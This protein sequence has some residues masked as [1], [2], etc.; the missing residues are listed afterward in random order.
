ME[1]N[2]FQW[3]GYRHTN[4]NLQAKRYFDKR[5]LDDADESPFVAKRTQV[6]MASSREEALQ[7]IDELTK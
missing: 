7:I 5:D 3:W 6:F 2:K 1:Q 4:G